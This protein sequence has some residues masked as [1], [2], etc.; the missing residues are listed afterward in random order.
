MG[1]GGSGFDVHATLTSVFNWGSGMRD[2]GVSNCASWDKWRHIELSE[3]VVGYNLIE[4]S[5]WGNV[6]YI[7]SVSPVT[8]WT[9]P[10]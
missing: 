3:F 4:N 2:A 9:L 6:L 5:L 7:R 10:S 8:Q 1:G